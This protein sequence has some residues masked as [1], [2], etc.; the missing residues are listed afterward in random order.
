MGEVHVN[1]LT[2]FDPNSIVAT[3]TPELVVD[4]Q[5][6]SFFASNSSLVL[7]DVVA[8]ISNCVFL[9]F[10]EI[11]ADWDVSTY[12]YRL[13]GVL[14]WR[15]AV[16]F[17]HC[18][19][20][21]PTISLGG[22]GISMQH[23]I[24]Q[25]RSCVFSKLSSDFGG[26]I[27]IGGLAVRAGGI[28]HWGAD[29]FSMSSRQGY[30]Y[31]IDSSAATCRSRNSGGVMSVALGHLVYIFN[32]D[33]A[34]SSARNYGGLIHSESGGSVVLLSSSITSASARIGGC[35]SIFSGSVFMVNTTLS[36]C[37]ALRG[38]GA[39][40]LVPAI[41]AHPLFRD[42]QGDLLD[43]QVKGA[44]L[45]TSVGL[46]SSFIAY[47]FTPNIKTVF[48]YCATPLQ[49]RLHCEQPLRAG[50]HVRAGRWCCHADE[51]WGQGCVREV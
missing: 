30:M 22:G 46:H 37:S 12:G 3:L 31:L 19:F 41:T 16:T 8:R 39:V 14:I 43:G 9:Q 25:C 50:Y 24:V 5:G 29:A 38:G 28:A 26:A 11:S 35:I 42:A 48:F 20:T 36:A 1:R 32:S 27:S 10:P 47:V 45:Q 44:R 18:T 4:C 15:S 23:S 2:S 51:G 34:R 7:V 49:V 21:S 17:T 6:G 33:L 13:P 40:S